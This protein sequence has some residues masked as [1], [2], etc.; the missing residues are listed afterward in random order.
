[1]RK[2]IS[3]VLAVLLLAV[4]AL[5]GCAKE[6]ADPLQV[7]L[8]QG[9]GSVSVSAEVYRYYLD[10]VMHKPEDFG[11]SAD[12]GMVELL[13][14]AD[15]LCRRYVAVISSDH[16]TFD[17]ASK[18]AVADNTANLWRIFGNYYEKIGVS[19]QTI[20]KIQTAQACKEQLFLHLYDKDGKEPVAEDAITAYFYN[21]Y[22]AFQF[23]RAYMTHTDEAG[24]VTDLD[25]EG[26][27]KLKN[28]MTGLLKRV[29]SGDSM[30]DVAIAGN[31]FLVSNTPTAAVVQKD[32]NIYGEEAFARIFALE[33]GAAALLQMDSYFMLVQK[34]DMTQ[35]PESFYG[36]YRDACLHG[37]QDATFQKAVDELCEAYTVSRNARAAQE[38][39]KD[40][41]K[42][43]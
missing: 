40:L 13:G 28:Q 8:A 42:V 41:Q 30:E 32:N 7:K 6:S 24:N 35:S 16:G 27:A 5:C 25:E 20:Q 12:S 22:V 2:I 21:N 10:K 9:E 38:I 36:A 18:T 14:A 17:M 19:K 29:E 3:G 26:I 15:A 11:L 37:L 34:T 23:V 1:M 31:A 4:T 43:K 33:N 39:Y